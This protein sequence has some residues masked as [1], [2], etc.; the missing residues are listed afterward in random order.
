MP[1]PE[2]W[3]RQTTTVRIEFPESYPHAC[4]TLCVP[5]E[6]PFTDTRPQ[7][8]LWS[9]KDGWDRYDT[10]LV[11]TTWV[12]DRDS[13]VTAL[14]AMMAHLRNPGPINQWEDK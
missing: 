3:N 8:L 7:W 13:S 6:L 4:P 2:G 1:L 9:K 10:H 14:R 5:A 11:T 12:P